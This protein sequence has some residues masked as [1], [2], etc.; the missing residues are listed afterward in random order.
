[1]KYALLIAFCSLVIFSCEKWHLN[2][3]RRKFVGKYEIERSEGCCTCP[4]E[5]THITL[6]IDYGSNDSTV[7]I[8]NDELFIKKSGDIQGYNVSYGYY[9]GKFKG[10]SIQVFH[11]N[12][13][14]GCQYV[15]SYKGPR[16]SKKP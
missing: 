13:S 5:I 15:I 7:T 6:S 11:T 1:M 9:L 3:Y 12:G 4:P 10:D 14:L 2:D 16:I 8:L